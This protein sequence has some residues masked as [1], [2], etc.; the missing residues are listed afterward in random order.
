MAGVKSLFA[1]IALFSLIPV[2][3]GR[4]MATPTVFTPLVKGFSWQNSVTAGGQPLPA[5]EGETGDTIGIVSDWL[6]EAGI[7]VEFKDRIRP[8]DLLMS[9]NAVP[10]GD[11]QQYFDDLLTPVRSR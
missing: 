8:G 4:P 5:G 7:E 6:Q 10:P 9:A 2:I 1:L 11:A 3:T